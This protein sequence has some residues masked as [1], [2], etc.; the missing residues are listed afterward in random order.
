MAKT[1]DLSAVRLCFVAYLPDE[2]GLLTRALP[3]VF[4]QPI[5]DQSKC[6]LMVIDCFST[7]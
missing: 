4:S 6:F 7:L 3:A 1:I 2:N 5:Y